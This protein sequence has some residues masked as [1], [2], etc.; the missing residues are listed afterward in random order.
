MTAA[1]KKLVF[2]HSVVCPR[3]Q[4]SGLALRRVL[5]KHPDIELTKVEFLTNRDRAREAGVSSIPTLVSRGRSLTGIVLTPARIERFL[6]ELDTE[7]S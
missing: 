4:I 6:R 1:G 2:Y 7:P 5:G 3:C